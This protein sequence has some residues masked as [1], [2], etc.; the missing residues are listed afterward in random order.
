MAEIYVPNYMSFN[1]DNTFLG[2]YNGLRFKL[3]PVKPE[4]QEPY[5]QAEY[6]YG[7]M[8]YENSAMDGRETFPLTEEGIAAMRQRLLDLAAI[9]PPE[10][11]A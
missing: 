11:K 8:S 6:W 1:N 4:D 5:I 10:G 3:T 9:E 2:S 7:P